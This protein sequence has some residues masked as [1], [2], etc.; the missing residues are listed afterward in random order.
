MNAPIRGSLKYYYKCLETCFLHAPPY[1]Y[2]LVI[3]KNIPHDNKH[4]VL[5]GGLDCSNVSDAIEILNPDIVD[6]SLGVENE[7]KTGK[8]REKVANF[9]TAVRKSY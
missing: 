3:L 6:V 2:L 9:I 8:N 7:T 4:F 5:A 1:I